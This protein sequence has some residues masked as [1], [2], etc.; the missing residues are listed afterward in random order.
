MISQAINTAH[1]D[2]VDVTASFSGTELHESGTVSETI[3][4]D[5]T[6]A[7]MKALGATTVDAATCNQA[8]GGAMQA[9]GES[10]CAVANGGCSCTVTLT[11]PLDVT[12]PYRIEGNRF[13]GGNGMVSSDYCVSGNTATIVE[14]GLG[15]SGRLRLTRVGN[16]G[17]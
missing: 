15:L 9:G 12:G 4:F 13:V 17:P 2:A 8:A 7:C 10:S 11:Q 3:R 5:F 6:S 14:G 16:A 1:Y